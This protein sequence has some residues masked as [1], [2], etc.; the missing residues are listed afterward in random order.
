MLL[1][2]MLNLLPLVFSLWLFWSVL[3]SLDSL[4]ISLL[5][6]VGWADPVNGSGFSLIIV[7][8]MLVGLSFSVSPI[9]W[10]YHKTESQLLRFPLFKTVYGASKDLAALVGQD[11]PQV[12]K[13]TVLIKQANGSYI[14][15]FITAQQ[16]PD[17]LSQALPDEDW[18][19]VLFQLSYQVAG[20]TSLVLRKDLIEVDWS[21]EEA[22]RFMLTAGVSQTVS[23]HNHSVENIHPDEKVN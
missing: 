7:I 23:D 9:Q 8:F 20:V 10:I 12:N 14:V 2:G 13:Q 21:F 17:K 6:L 11:R 19:P 3:V 1:R 5:K 16:I 18:V 22:M 15:G 4:G